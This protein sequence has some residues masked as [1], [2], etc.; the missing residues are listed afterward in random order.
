MLLNPYRFGDPRFAN[1]VSLLHFDG[2]NASTTFTCQKGITY[3]PSGNVQITTAESLYGGASGQFDG[4]NDYLSASNAALALG[5]GDFCIEIACRKAGN[6]ASG[7]NSDLIL[8]DWRSAE[9]QQQML[10]GV[11]GST[12]GTIGGNRAFV[13]LNGSYVIH[14]AIATLAFQRICVERVGSTI[15]LY[16]EGSSAGTTSNSSNFSSSSLT[17][18]GRF[19]AVSGDRRSFNGQIDEFRLTVGAYRYNGNYTVASSPFPDA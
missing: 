16:A 13:Y 3:T 4:N 10:I 12:N 19:A 5:S 15:T 7:N 8:L 6:G 14:S 9:P 11:T 1:V 2:A 17:L 18:G